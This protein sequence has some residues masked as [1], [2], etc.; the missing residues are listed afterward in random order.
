MSHPQQKRYHMINLPIPIPILRHQKLSSP[1]PPL[2]PFDNITLCTALAEINLLFILLP[3]FYKN[4]QSYNILV[5]LL[6]LLHI[7]I[8]AI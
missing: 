2:Y 8:F 3:P 6:Y 7:N 5:F 1:R 4:L